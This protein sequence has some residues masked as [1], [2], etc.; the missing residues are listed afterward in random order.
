M[1]LNSSLIAFRDTKFNLLKLFLLMLP[2][3]SK[4]SF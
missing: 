1:F 2:V 3:C 4:L